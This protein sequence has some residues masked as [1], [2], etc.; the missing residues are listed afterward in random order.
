MNNLPD[1]DQIKDLILN[2]IKKKI[3]DNISNGD[4]TITIPVYVYDM[5]KDEFN[6]KGYTIIK[7][8]END[9]YKISIPLLKNDKKEI[10]TVE[11]FKNIIDN[12]QFDKLLNYTNFDLSNYLK[13]YN[14]KNYFVVL[15]KNCKDEKVLKYVIENAID[16]ECEDNK[17]WRPI[18]YICEYS[19]P[20]MIKYIIDKGVDLECENDNKDRPIHCICLYST[21]E[22]IKYI[23]DKGVD[24]ECENDNKWKPI[25]YIC[26]F[27]SPEMIKYIIDKG[28]DLECETNCKWRPINF[29]CENSTQEMIKYIID[30]GVDFECEDEFG[31]RPIHYICQYST[32]EMIKYIID[33]SVDLECEAICKYRPIHFICLYSTPEMIKYII[34]KGI[35]IK[36][37]NNLKL[38]I[39]IKEN[40]KLSDEE[41][42]NIT[43][44]VTFKILSEK[45]KNT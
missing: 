39:K 1:K 26:K 16:L 20:E 44:Y 8:E 9:N 14:M 35:K 36:F 6:D 40:N 2:D 28:V 41:K 7:K 10:I 12:K 34:D 22:M 37:D 21:P 33:K 25:H 3:C 38:D 32:P 11:I 42:N 4:T 15:L 17:E 43:E 45:Y 5:F 27:S 24:L 18:H 29:I 13:L 23:I 30:K 31:K 19:T